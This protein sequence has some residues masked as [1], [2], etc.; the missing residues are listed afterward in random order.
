MPSS[1]VSEDSDGTHIHKI[2]NHLFFFKFKKNP[3]VYPFTH[4]PSTSELRWEV[5]RK[6]QLEALRPATLPGDLGGNKR[7]PASKQGGRQKPTPESRPPTCRVSG[8]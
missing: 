8:I 4:N 6:D 2:D 5:E 3:Q 7:E 1:H